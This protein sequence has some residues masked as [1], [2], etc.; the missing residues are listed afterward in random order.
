MGF[1]DGYFN[2]RLDDDGALVQHGI[3]PEDYSVDVAAAA[4]DDF[5]R[6]TP[7]DEPL[8]LMLTPFGP[9]DPSTPAPRHADLFPDLTPFRPPSYNE[10]DMSDKPE[11][12]R[13][14]PQLDLT[15]QA[16]LDDFVKDQYRALQAVDDAVGKVV[17]ALS[18]TG[19]L[20]TTLIVFMSDNGLHWGEHR[21]TKKA[22]P[23]QESLHVP[24]VLRYDPLL[25]GPST[26]S[27]LVLNVD[28]APTF[29][30]LAG[31]TAPGAEGMDLF[32]LL[33][34]TTPWRK[35]FVLEHITPQAPTFCGVMGRRYTYAQYSTGEEELY[36][37]RTDPYELVNVAADPDY[38]ATL[39]SKRATTHELCDPPPPDFTFTH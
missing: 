11:Y 29:A 16:K 6:T 37:R 32:Q 31:T 24:M 9:H 25:D 14:Q 28:L 21:W 36:D 8:F 27:H 26:D 3:S 7:A 33:S 5:I 15:Q 23:Y 10:P 13:S 22:L 30:S 20:G 4:A 1:E 2:Y 39:E 18:D 38:A 19:R 12:I 34:G 17:T 35:Q